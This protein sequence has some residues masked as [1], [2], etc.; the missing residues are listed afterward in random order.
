[1]MS[2]PKE[3]IEELSKVILL[4]DGK[5]SKANIDR[6]SRQLRPIS[7]NLDVH[8]LAIKQR[9]KQAILNNSNQGEGIHMVAQFEKECNITR[10]LNSSLLLPFL[11]LLE[12][13]CYPKE[14]KKYFSR[15]LDCLL[16][17]SDAADE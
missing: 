6:L 7:I 16:Y 14:K 13:L 5:I 3:I 4:N 1:M 15:N 9:I 2:N 11:A 12:P 10:R 8:S 17:T